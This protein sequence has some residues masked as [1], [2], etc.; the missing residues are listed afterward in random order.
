MSIDQVQALMQALTAITAL[1]QQQSGF[2]PAATA[3]ALTGGGSLGAAAVP[4][5]ASTPAPASMTA[6]AAGGNASDAQLVEGTLN[7]LRSTPAGAHIVDRLL[8]NNAKV[9]VI[10]D[11]Q[12]A[13]MGQADAHAFFDPNIDT[14]FLRRSDLATNQQMAAIELAHEGTHLLD[15]IAG[16]NKP[17][18]AEA[19]ARAQ[20]LGG[21]TPQ[22]REVEAQARFEEMIISEARAFTFAGQ[23]A[24]QLGYTRLASSDPTLI[25]ARGSNSQATYAQVF[26]ALLKGPYNTEHRTA[27]VRN[28]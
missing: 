12:F 28:F 16:L 26:Q 22:A 5:M 6:L 21:T 1:M 17:L 20:A 18:F 25:S 27:Q 10:S 19:Q 9:N 23:V 24:Q 14:V 4:A 13:Q 7:V 11:A 3:N 15:D 8:A 2:A